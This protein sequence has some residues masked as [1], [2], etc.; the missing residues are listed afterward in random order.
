MKYIAFSHYIYVE[1]KRVKTYAIAV[2]ARFILIKVKWDI[3]TNGQAVRELVK[4]L[5][6]GQVKLIHLDD[7]IE[8]FYNEYC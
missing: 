3:S 5:N 6:K 8:D 2:L 4:R 1:N 7:I